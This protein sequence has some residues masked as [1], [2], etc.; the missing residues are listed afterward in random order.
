MA[1]ISWFV[2][3]DKAR[4]LNRQSKANANFQRSF[5]ERT[6]GLTLPGHHDV[7]TASDPSVSGAAVANDELM[8]NSSLYRI[9]QI[10]AQE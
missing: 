7:P 1:V 6:A 9:Y 3:F 2:M 4:Y 10:G 8:K 5:R